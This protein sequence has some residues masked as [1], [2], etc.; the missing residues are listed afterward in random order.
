MK[1]SAYETSRGPAVFRL[2]DHL[3]RM[4][5]SAKMFLM[6]IPFSCDEL[7][8]VTNEL[9][10]INKLTACYVRPIAYRGFG[11][12]MGVNPERNPIDVAIAVWRWGTYLGDE[13]LQN[14]V[15]MTISSW[16]RHDEIVILTPFCRASS[17][18]YVP[19]AHTAIATS[20]GFC[21]GFTP[22]SPPNPRNA[23]GLT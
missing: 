8:R 23:I 1:G 12:E 7:I 10:K 9:I 2:R 15:R 22:I 4:E 16:R 17:P 11:G 13:A 3:E 6:E 19:H 20:I 21:S 14:G 18:R 5:R